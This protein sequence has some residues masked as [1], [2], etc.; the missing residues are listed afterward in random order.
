[1]Q[2]DYYEPLDPQPINESGEIPHGQTGTAV[3][4]SGSEQQQSTQERAGEMKQRAQEQA[5]N[6]AT[7][8]RE[9]SD[10]GMYKASEGLSSAAAQLREK[11]EQRGGKQAQVASK[12]ADQL[13]RT[14]TYLRDHDTQQVWDDVERFV[15]EN[16]MQAAAGALFAGFV[17]GRILR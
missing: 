10:Q 7:M 12:M 17:L 9:R 15:K 16:P 3:P 11:G 4:V 14:S 2:R 5:S 8:A 6:V 13:D 1:M